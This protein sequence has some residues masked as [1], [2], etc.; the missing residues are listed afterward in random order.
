VFVWPP[1]VPVNVTVAD[2]A[3]VPAEAVNVSSEAVPGVSV[4]EEGFA[5]TPAGNPLM[6]IGTLEENPF[7][8]VARTETGVAVPFAANVTAAGVT[9]SEKPAAGSVAASTETVATVLAL[10][11]LT[12][13]EKVNLEVAVGAVEPAAKLSGVETPG[14]TDNVAGDIVIPVGS[15]ETVTGTA[16]APEAAVSNSEA[17]APPA[18]ATTLIFAGVTVSVGTIVLSPMLLLVL[19]LLHETSPVTSTKLR[20]S[21]S[22]IWKLRLHGAVE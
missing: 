7:C 15:P 8:P 10:W 4:S 16:L 2:P 12:V 6:V 18:P 14:D 22:T 21:N 1:E 19:L 11:P 20:M 3:A 17:C 13:T 5:V 9:E